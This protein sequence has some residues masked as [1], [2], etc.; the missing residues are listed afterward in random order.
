MEI[1]KKENPR[2][3][4][5]EF[6]SAN[7]TG[8]LNI[9][10]ARAAALGDSCSN[11]LEAIGENVYREYYVNDYGNQVE[12][13]GISCLFRLLEQK[14]IKLKFS[15]KE[16][17]QVFYREE[18]GLPFPSEAYHG[19]YIIDALNE[20]QKNSTNRNTRKRNPSIRG[21]KQKKRLNRRSSGRNFKRTNNRNCS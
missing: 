4:I 18:E 16:K 19:E 17:N 13:L 7:P 11:L 6:V 5:F 2:R 1:K 21:N 10:S 12:L 3:I 20:I 15:I 8:P 9:V 14:G